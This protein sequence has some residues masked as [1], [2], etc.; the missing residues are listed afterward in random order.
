MKRE[1]GKGWFASRARKGFG[2]PAPSSKI[3]GAG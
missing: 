3:D 1:E 2:K